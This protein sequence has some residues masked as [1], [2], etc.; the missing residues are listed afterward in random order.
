MPTNNGEPRRLAT[1][2]PGKWRDLKAK[3]KAPS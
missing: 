1:H 3:A 2:S